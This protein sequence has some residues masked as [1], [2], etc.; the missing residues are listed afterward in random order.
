[1][2]QNVPLLLYPHFQCLDL[3][4]YYLDDF[5]TSNSA[6][7]P[8]SQTCITNNFSY[9]PSAWGCPW[10]FSFLSHALC[11]NIRKSLSALTSDMPRIP[12]LCTSYASMPL[13]WATGI[14]NLSNQSM[15]LAH[16]SAPFAHLWYI[17]HRVARMMHSNHMSEHVTFLL[18]TLRWLPF[19]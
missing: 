7:S 12:A 6:M 11:P 1:M 2:S 13:I 16:L 18:Q 5:N 8:P 17:I 4:T 19:P 14:L 9:R 15:F 3:D 10:L